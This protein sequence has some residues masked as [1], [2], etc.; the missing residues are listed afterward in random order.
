M[1]CYMNDVT[2]AGTQI[3]SVAASSAPGNYFML[4]GHCTYSLS[5][6]DVTTWIPFFLHI[7]DALDHQNVVIRSTLHT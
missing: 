3:A 5:H 1:Q 2:L 4:R 7:P 6:I